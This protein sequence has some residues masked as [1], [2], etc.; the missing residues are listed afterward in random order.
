MDESYAS[1]TSDFTPIMSKAKR[2]GAEVIT[3]G[4]YINDEITK[5]AKSVGYSPRLMMWAIGASDPNFRREL[6]EDADYVGATRTGRC[7]S[8]PLAT[9]SS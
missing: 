8:R 1:D 5:A 2:L 6:G 7:S 4:G 9:R 3:G